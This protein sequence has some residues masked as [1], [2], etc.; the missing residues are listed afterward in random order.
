MAFQHGA[1]QHEAFQCS[2][3][4]PLFNLTP[5]YPSRIEKDKWEAVSKAK[6]RLEEIL[7][8]FAEKPDSAPLQVAAATELKEIK[9]ELEP[10]TP[11]P[12]PDYRATVEQLKQVLAFIEAELRD[13]ERLRNL[14]ERRL[15]ILQDDDE[16]MLILSML[17]N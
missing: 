17:P 12:E 16:L 5:P 13:L 2:T 15:R 7:E 6:H 1:F 8:E 11:I 9:T 3:V 4:T 14:E 10:F